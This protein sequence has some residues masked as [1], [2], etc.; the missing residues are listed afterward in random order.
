MR[1]RVVF[2]LSFALILSVSCGF[3]EPDARENTSSLTPKDAE[4]V[5]DVFV[6]ATTT[7]SL[8]LPEIESLSGYSMIVEF[9]GSLLPQHQGLRERVADSSNLAR[10][11]METGYKVLGLPLVSPTG[12]TVT[13]LTPPEQMLLPMLTYLT[14][15]CSGIPAVEW[16]TTKP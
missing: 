9:L 5:T 16:S 10:C 1:M 8:E 13:T 7:T 2:S 12:V 4:P 15:V 11:M 6:D 14:E 3:V